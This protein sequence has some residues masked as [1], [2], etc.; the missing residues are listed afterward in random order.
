MNAFIAVV[1]EVRLGKP[2]DTELFINN[3]P[4]FNLTFTN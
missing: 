4:A 2:F 1:V 3:Y